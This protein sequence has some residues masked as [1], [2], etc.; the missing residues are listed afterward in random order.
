MNTPRRDWRALPTDTLRRYLTWVDEYDDCSIMHHDE[1][2]AA[3]QKLIDGEKPPAPGG[4]SSTEAR[5][6]FQVDHQ[7]WG[8]P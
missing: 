2:V 1:L 6:W 3:I 7:G 8:D 4:G 5:L